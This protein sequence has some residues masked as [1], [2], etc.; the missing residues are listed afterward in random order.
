[1]VKVLI[2]KTSNIAFTPSSLPSK[3]SAKEKRKSYSGNSCVTPTLTVAPNSLVPD[4][5]GYSPLHTS[6][7]LGHL[8]LLTLLLQRESKDAIKLMINNDSNSVDRKDIDSPYHLAAANGHTK[9]LKILIEYVRPYRRPFLIFFQDSELYKASWN[10]GRGSRTPLH[11]ACRRGHHETAK[12]LVVGF[13]MDVNSTDAFGVSPTL[14]AARCM[15][16]TLF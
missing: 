8:D 6:C 13:K 9:L 4:H 11:L 14:L 10:L 3:A 15:R 7:A 5:F 1:M 16:V 2:D 12:L